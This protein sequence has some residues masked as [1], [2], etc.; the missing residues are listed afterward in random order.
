MKRPEQSGE[1]AT[2]EDAAND[3]ATR[4]KLPPLRVPAAPST[5]QTAPPREAPP[6]EDRLPPLKPPAEGQA[7]PSP[8]VTETPA[9]QVPVEREPSARRERSGLRVALWIFVPAV[10]LASI[11]AVALGASSGSSSHGT[12]LSLGF[13]RPGTT[14]VYRSQ[15]VMRGYVQLQAASQSPFELSMTE[16][17]STR[18]DAAAGAD[19]KLALA[20]NDWGLFNGQNLTPVAIDTSVVVSS[21]GRI[22]SGGKIPLVTSQ[23]HIG[24]MPGTDLFLPLLPNHPVQVGDTWSVSYRRPFPIPD[25]GTL[26]YQTTNKL[27]RFDSLSDPPTAVVSTTGR[28]PVD[29]TVDMGRLRRLAPDLV[30][31]LISSLQLTP[32][33]RFEYRGVVAYRLTSTLD[34]LS[35]QLVSSRVNGNVHVRVTAT[36]APS[37]GSFTIDSS[38]VQVT[39]RMS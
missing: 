5:E 20:T 37:A 15:R 23:G 7:A 2:A 6:T 13:G 38:L 33:S 1:E 31:Q 8:I 28:V 18:V 11:V 29:V 25:S 3:P 22:R 24:G 17:E 26:R 32:Q 39:R 9:A 27:V 30:D 4:P 34:T 12:T 19:T 21:D 36:G 16:M 10:I 35:H 14:A